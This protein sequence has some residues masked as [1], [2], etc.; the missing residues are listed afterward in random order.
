MA[1]ETK[2]KGMSAGWKQVAR[3]TCGIVIGAVIVWIL[4]TITAKPRAWVEQKVS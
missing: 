3:L 4:W 1:G 2:K